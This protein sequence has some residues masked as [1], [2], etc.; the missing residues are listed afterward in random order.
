[1]TFHRLI[2]LLFI[3]I[4]LVLIGCGSTS[5]LAQTPVE[6]AELRSEIQMIEIRE[7]NLK[8]NYFPPVKDGSPGIV[9]LGGSEGGIESSTRLAKAL[10]EKGFGTLAIAYFDFEDLPQY[11][12]LIPLETFFTGIDWLASQSEIDGSNI[13]LIGGSKGGEAALLVA[14]YRPDIT[15]VVAY[16]PSN[17]AW[18]E[19]NPEKY[20]SAAPSSSWSLNGEPLP[21]VSYDYAQPF[22]LLVEL[23]TNSLAA[24]PAD[25]EDVIIKVENIN[26]PVLLLSGTDDQLWDASTMSDLVVERAK[27]NDFSFEIKHL[28]Y[29]DAGHYLL[30]SGA[31][32]SIEGYELDPRFLE[33][34]GTTEGM[35]K[36]HVDAWAAT[37][38]FFIDSLQD[39]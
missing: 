38:Q 15:A 35:R 31:P 14:S 19:I 13:G 22:E 1:M 24:H 5:E 39:H 20:F 23:Y 11:L 25:D 37:S 2:V 10:A 28:K 6:T 7:P 33:F 36:A 17:V 32:E 16:V 18:Q 9:V 12:E 34:G 26:G 8:A 4:A 27:Q 29:E 30:Y 21:F 3:I